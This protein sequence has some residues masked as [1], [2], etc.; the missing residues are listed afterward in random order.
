M[1]DHKAKN[2]QILGIKELA[3]AQNRIDKQNR[4]YIRKYKKGRQTFG[5]SNQGNKGR[6]F[7]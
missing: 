7:F 2:Q 5:K 3:P 6:R 4:E 1:V